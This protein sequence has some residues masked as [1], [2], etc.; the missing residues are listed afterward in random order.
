[1][2]GDNRKSI[3][4]S[5]HMVFAVARLLPVRLLVRLRRLMRHDQLLLAFLTVL[6]GGLT[7]GGT[8][9]IRTTIALFH[10]LAYGSG[11]IRLRDKQGEVA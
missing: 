4:G 11:D 2:D 9:V 3:V 8:I 1:V 10:L 6:V 5:L 7:E